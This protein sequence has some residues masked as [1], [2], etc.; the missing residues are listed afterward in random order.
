MKG[1]M[2]ANTP[3]FFR[4]K[5]I[6]SGERGQGDKNEMK[7]SMPC[8]DL[9]FFDKETGNLAFSLEKATAI[10]DYPDDRNMPMVCFSGFSIDDLTVEKE[11]ADNVVYMLP[12]SEE[13]I[14]LLKEK[15]GP[16]CVLFEPATFISKL[17]DFSAKTN[18]PYA[19][20]PIKYRESNDLEKATAFFSRKTDRFFFKDKDLAYQREY[21]LII[22]MEL[23]ED[24]F[25]VI[26][27][28]NS[29]E[30]KKATVFDTDELKNLRLW[31]KRIDY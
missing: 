16:Y 26:S 11:D 2:Y 4:D 23:P 14:V 12:F 29:I 17:N 21:R 31:A 7:Y 8:I 15:F 25:I 6:E 30:K 22:Q 9:Q 10:I 20:S 3:Q 27:S 13:E 28:F 19:I 1:K 24:H 5:E 18:V